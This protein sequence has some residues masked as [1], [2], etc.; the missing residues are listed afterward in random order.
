MRKDFGNGLHLL[1][2]KLSFRSGA[3]FRIVVTAVVGCGKSPGFKN[4]DK[5]FKDLS[6]AQKVAN[7]AIVLLND[8]ALNQSLHFELE[9]A[10]PRRIV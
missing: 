3:I 1:K 5:V 6:V 8:L 7:L 2:T 10:F 4:I 9:A